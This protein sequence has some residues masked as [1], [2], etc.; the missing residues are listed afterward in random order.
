[1][2]AVIDLFLLCL[3]AHSEFMDEHL[4]SDFIVAFV[5]ALAVNIARPGAAKKQFTSTP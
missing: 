4:V 5:R 1:M 2:Y 3:V